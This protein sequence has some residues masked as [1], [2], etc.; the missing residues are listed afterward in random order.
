MMC[1]LAEYAEKH[2]ITI[3]LIK[4]YMKSKVYDKP[5]KDQ[6]CPVWVNLFNGFWSC[7]FE[8]NFIQFKL[9]SNYVVQW[10]ILSQV[11]K[12]SCFWEHDFFKKIYY[13]IGDTE[14]YVQLCAVIMTLS[15]FLIP[16]KVLKQRTKICSALSGIF[17][18]KISDWPQNKKLCKF[19]FPLTFTFN[20]GLV[21]YGHMKQ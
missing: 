3:F 15:W 14:F 19:N 17:E 11:M 4:I 16:Q 6:Q 9:T 21:V 2:N 8:N 1:V 18:L 7:W 13:P 5:S 20:G 10:Q 12:F